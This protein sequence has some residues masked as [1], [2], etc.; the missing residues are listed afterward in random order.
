MK[1]T[2]FALV[3]LA[4]LL[5]APAVRAA[6]QPS[7]DAMKFGY[8]DFNRALNETEEGK[9]AKSTLKAEFNERQQKLDI[10]QNELKK[11]KEDLDKQRLILSQDALKA[12]EDEYRN[13]FM[14]LQQKLGTFKQE[15]AQKE[16][17]MTAGL[18]EKLKGIV[19]DLGS[20]NSYTMILEKS[21]DVVLYAPTINDL[22]DEVIKICNSTP[23]AKS[24]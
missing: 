22:T 10:V 11:M 3:A 24:K 2:I 5:A 20:K 16:A 14:E 18:L 19:K 17:A 9:T 13:K 23:K 21:Q 7:Q 6:G 4:V 15:M 12:K 1:K 8:V